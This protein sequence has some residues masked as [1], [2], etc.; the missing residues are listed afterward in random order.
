[1]VNGEQSELTDITS[2][3]PQGS[4][5]GSVLFLIFANDFT[6]GI[7]TTVKLFADD[8]KL[9]RG[10]QTSEYS[11]ELQTDLFNVM[12]WS[13]K[14]QLLFNTSKCKVMHICTT[15]ACNEFTMHALPNEGMIE[16][17]PEENDVGVTF[18]KELKFSKYIAIC[19][20]KETRELDYSEKTLNTVS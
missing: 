10:I 13:E 2:G 20:N 8:T 14:W 16:T 1:M 11:Q 12:Q 3:I 5:F 9:Y 18:D 19:V 6:D 4:V 7:S 17:V 15:N